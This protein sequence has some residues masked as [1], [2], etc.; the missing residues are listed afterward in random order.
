MKISKKGYKHWIC[1]KQHEFDIKWF[2]FL[3]FLAIFLYT[4]NIF[5]LVR[6]RGPVYYSLLQYTGV[7][8]CLCVINCCWVCTVEERNTKGLLNVWY[9][10][11]LTFSICWFRGKVS[12]SCYGYF[13]SPWRFLRLLRWL[14]MTIHNSTATFSSSVVYAIQLGYINASKTTQQGMDLLVVCHTH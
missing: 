10:S 3:N 4:F 14:T 11:F 6:K 13:Y 8:V 7:F 1:K 12:F 5:S 2:L 9:A